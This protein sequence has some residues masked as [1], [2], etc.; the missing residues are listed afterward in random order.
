M[1]KTLLPFLFLLNFNFLSAQELYLVKLKEK[2]N[3]SNYIANPLQMLSQRSL[4]RRM[5]YKVDLDE[6]DVPISLERIKQVKQLDLSYIGETKW[7]NTI[8]VEVFDNTVISQLENLPFVDSVTSLVRNAQKANFKK[9]S[10]SNDLIVIVNNYNY[11]DSENFI[12]QINLE[13]L[14]TEGFSGEGVYIGV[15]DA[16]FPGVDIID[17]FKN[18]RNENRIVDT[19]DFVENKA[20]VYDANSHGTNVLS[21]MAAEIDGEYIG[22][23]PKANYLL[24]RSEDFLSETPKELLYWIQAAERADSVGVDVINTSL[25]YNKFDDPRY[26]FTYRDM[27]GKT[28]LISQGAEIAVTRGILVVN[29]AGNE[30][31]S[32]WKYISAPADVEN[33]FTIGATDRNNQPAPFTSYGPN[34]NGSLK[35]NISSLG[36]QILTY[37]P[38]GGFRISSGTSFSSPIIAGAMALLIQKLP[39][40]PLETIKN[41]VQ[42]SGSLYNNPSDR[43]GYGVPNFYRASQ[44]LL[45]INDVKAQVNKLKVYPNPFTNEVKVETNNQIKQIEIYNLVGQKIANSSNTSII[46]TNH[47]KSGVYLI[48]VIDNKGNL[49]TEKII[50]K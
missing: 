39:T 25:S 11:G 15:I 20:D 41:K 21:T 45:S 50:K 43:L 24:Y 47:L 4:D 30:G 32:D 8:M 44:E 22:S 12:N 49:F 17:A 38:S 23:A 1:K 35:P 46:K 3:I 29:S 5:K 40:T 34:Y 2:E 33:V 18:L 37:V 6:K 36:H 28:S 27:D 19:Y 10:K 7:L 31:N 14:H 42:E 16:G 9:Q 48:K 13:P 26:D